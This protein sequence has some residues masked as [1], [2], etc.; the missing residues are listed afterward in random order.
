MSETNISPDKSDGQLILASHVNELK[1][2]MVTTF[3]GR[4]ANGI[5]SAGQNLGSSAYPWGIGYIDRLISNNQLIDFSTIAAE[6][7]ALKSGKTRTTSLQP[8]FLRANGV[9][10]SVIIQGASTF[11]VMVINTVLTTLKVDLNLTSLTLAG[12]GP[13]NRCTINNATYTGQEST[14]WDYEGEGNTPILVDGMGGSVTAKIGQLVALRNATTDEIM[15]AYVKSA[16]ELTN[17]KRG[18][19]L[20]NTGTPINRQSLTD[21]QNLELMSLGWVFI[22]SDAVT[23]EVSYLNPQYSFE[24]PLSPVTGLYWFDLQVKQWKRYNGTDFVVINRILLGLVVIDQ[25]ACVATRS[26][27][28]DLDYLDLNTALFDLKDITATNIISRNVNN[29][30]SVNGTTYDIR[31]KINF[32]ITTDL[33]TGLTEAANTTYYCYITEKG[34]RRIDIIR[35]S[36][37]S[38]ILKGIYHPHNTW[39]CV[40]SFFNDASSNIVSVDNANATFSNN[41]NFFESSQQAITIAG[42]LTIA[43]G[44]PRQ[45]ILYKGFLKCTTAEFNYSIG[46]ET[47]ALE[48]DANSAGAASGISVVPDATNL[49]IRFGNSSAVFFVIN[50]TTGVLNAITPTNWRLVMRAWA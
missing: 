42:S 30:I 1:A 22:G 8:D 4:D 15:L 14:K 5:M 40:A 26:R 47:P 6:T 31:N 7:N 43:H 46:D 3:S 12:S 17:V 32:N 49:N 35:P 9:T 24:T 33:V 29:A 50:K 25:T 41:V 44:L 11:L 48:S 34:Q 19:F 39:L 21:N 10:N 20:N 18:Y 16:T 13:S 36:P 27:E 37:S 2:A 28:F 23:T 45:P 38:S